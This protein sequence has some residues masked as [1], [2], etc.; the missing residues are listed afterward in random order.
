MYPPIGAKRSLLKPDVPLGLPKKDRQDTLKRWNFNCTCAMCKQTEKQ[1]WP[2]EVRRVRLHEIYQSLFEYEENTVEKIHGL[3][4]EMMIIIQAEGLQ[5]QLCEFYAAIARSYAAA[6]AIKEARENAALSDEYWV[7]YGG[8]EHEN[9][10][11]QKELWR[12][13]RTEELKLLWGPKERSY[14]FPDEEYDELD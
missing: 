8:E 14:Y 1:A 6:G 13:I 5:T 10:E 9:I 7:R 2:N 11:G 12:D 3:V 4:R